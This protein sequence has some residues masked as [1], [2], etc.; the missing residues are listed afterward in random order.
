VSLLEDML[1]LERVRRRP[2]DLEREAQAHPVLHTVE[3]QRLRAVSASFAR[4]VLGRWWQPRFGATF[5]QVADPAGLATRLIAGDAFEAAVGEDE[6]AAVLIQGVLA[7]REAG[8]LE[9]PEWLEDLLAYEYLL[10]VGLPRRAQGLEPDAAAEARLFV[11]RVR[12]FEGG[13]LSRPLAVAQF[14]VDVAALREG[15]EPEEECP[16]LAF[17]WDADGALE[18]PLSYEAADAL[19]LLASG[20]SDAVVDEAFGEHGPALREALTELGFVA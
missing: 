7:L 15:E 5:S 3:P 1:A 9:A 16:P 4:H 20:A 14:A 19:E 10:E 8:Q 17:G 6:T 12:W 13:R 11:G 18:V 2:A